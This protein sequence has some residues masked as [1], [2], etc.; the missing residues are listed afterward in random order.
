MAKKA[1]ERQLAYRLCNGSPKAPR[2]KIDATI[3]LTHGHKDQHDGEGYDH[4]DMCQ[5]YA[6]PSVIPDE[7]TEESAR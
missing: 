4:D 2:G 6:Q 5:R 7:I 3:N 1:A